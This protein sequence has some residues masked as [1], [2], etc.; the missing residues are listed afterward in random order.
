MLRARREKERDNSAKSLFDLINVKLGTDQITFNIIYALIL[1][2]ILIGLKIS[3]LS[4]KDKVRKHVFFGLGMD[5]EMLDFSLIV[6]IK[7]VF[8]LI[9]Q[10]MIYVHISS[11]L[12]GQFS[13]FCGFSAFS[14]LHFLVLTVG[15][16][17]GKRGSISD[18]MRN[19]G[20]EV[21]GVS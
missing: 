20:S 16:A 1:R 6:C 17:G 18:V 4:K 21:P 12:I 13:C 2:V 9:N 19:R 15:C 14:L 11:P 8:S 10:L 7:N 5:V 3:F